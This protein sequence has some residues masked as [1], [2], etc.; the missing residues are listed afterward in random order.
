MVVYD[1]LFK[2]N[3]PDEIKYEKMFE[4]KWKLRI[5]DSL[6]FKAF[7]YYFKSILKN[8]GFE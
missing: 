2:F 1:E 7:S 5:Q 6:T 3:D 4:N 8:E